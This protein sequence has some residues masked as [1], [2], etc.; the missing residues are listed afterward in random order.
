MPVSLVVTEKQVFAM[1]CL[2]I[3]P[4][5]QRNFDGIQWWMF[6]YFVLDSQL[7]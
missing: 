3:F 2:N 5:F 4:V 1:C 6:E 7:F